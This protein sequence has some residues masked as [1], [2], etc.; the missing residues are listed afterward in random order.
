MKKAP[1]IAALILL[2]VGLSV[3]AAAVC[4]RRKSGRCGTAPAR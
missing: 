4:R 3:T 2:A 1:A